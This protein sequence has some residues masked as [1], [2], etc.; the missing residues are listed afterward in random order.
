MSPFSVWALAFSLMK[1]PIQPLAQDESGVL[2]FKANAI[3]QHLLE[4]GGIDMNQIAKLDF[5]ADDRQQFAQL[6]GYSLSGY[7]DLGYVDEDAYSTAYDTAYST[8]QET[9]PEHAP[10]HPESCFSW[11]AEISD[12]LRITRHVRNLTLGEVAK[13]TGISKAVI[14]KLE[15]PVRGS[16]MAM[17]SVTAV[18]IAMGIEPSVMLGDRT[19]FVESLM[20][21]VTTALSPQSK[22]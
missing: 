13:M 7:G 12:R 2:R 18:S 11:V 1:H 17:E 15:T 3:V 9:S 5:T 19:A 22:P 10:V 8:A 6:I 4:S 21:A 20:I 14:G 16:R